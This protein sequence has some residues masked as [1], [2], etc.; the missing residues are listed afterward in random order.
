MLKGF[1]DY[2]YELTDYEKTVLLPA[3][4]KSFNDK[5]VGAA[6]AITNKSIVA[7]LKGKGMKISDARVR[8]VIAYIR[9]NGLIPGL[10]ATSKGYYITRDSGELENYITS[11]TGRINAIQA[12]KNE[13]LKY[14][15]TL[16]KP[17]ELWH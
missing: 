8:K 4:L 5:R 17:I 15:K 16:K 12:V 13:A 10:M 7:A 14:L 1:E 9:V 6:H 3:F 2:T 11:L